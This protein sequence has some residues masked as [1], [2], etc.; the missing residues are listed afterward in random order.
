MVQWRLSKAHFTQMPFEGVLLPESF[1]TVR[2]L[3]TGEN[4]KSE[5]FRR[6]TKCI[7]R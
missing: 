7:G 2:I 3:G 1:S 5:L 6:I 4:K